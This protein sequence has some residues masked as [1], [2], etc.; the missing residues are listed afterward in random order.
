[1]FFSGVDSF[2]SA[3]MQFSLIR[4]VCSFYKLTQYVLVALLLAHCIEN[5]GP[6]RQHH[7]RF[8]LFSVFVERNFFLLGGGDSVF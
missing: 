3:L 6:P 1:V 7:P 4:L 8:N 2:H 5:K